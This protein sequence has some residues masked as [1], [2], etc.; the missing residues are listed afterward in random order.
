MRTTH[1]VLVVPAHNEAASIA[2]CLSSARDSPLP[3]GFDWR[4][5]RI[6]DDGSTDQTAEHVRSWARENQTIPVTLVS[7]SARRGKIATV[8]SCHEALIG[9]GHLQDII[10][11]MD[12]D[13]T[14]K[15][16]ALTVLLAE[17]DDSD[18]VAA[19]GL[20]LP[21]RRR[22]GCRGAAFQIELAANFAQ[23]LGPNFT[24]IE[25]RL[26]AYRLGALADFHLQA[27]LIVEDTQITEFLVEHKLRVRSAF[28]A[29]I[30]VTPAASYWDF[31]KQTYRAFQAAALAG[32][33]FPSR[34]YLTTPFARRALLLTVRADPIGAVA[35]TAARTVAALL[36][37]IRPVTFTDQFLASESTKV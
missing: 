15:S 26:Y 24:R 13:V 35:Y 21:N 5:W 22:L 27:G 11:F 37:G 25:G 16:D 36:H 2:R 8:K 4:E 32:P 31:Y 34:T 23:E 6:L 28:G 7:A 14:I 10:V 30:N 3:R 18:V 9:Q 33:R 20:S 19:T 29:V 12:A 17:F 1:C